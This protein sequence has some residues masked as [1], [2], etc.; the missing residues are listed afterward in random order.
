[1]TDKVPLGCEMSET[2]PKGGASDTK[3]ARTQPE[4]PRRGNWIC[5]KSERLIC[6]NSA[7]NASVTKRSAHTGA[8]SAEQ[9]HTSIPHRKES[10]T[11]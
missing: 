9:E 8:V 4:A 1:M 6:A 11:A 10:I 7:A 3:L 2:C 5:P